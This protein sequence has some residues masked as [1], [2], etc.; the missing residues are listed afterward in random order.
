VLTDPQSVTLS[1]TAIS[2]PRLDERADTHVYTNR[3]SKVDLFV[4]QRVD[5]NSV[6]RSSV[7]LVTTVNV[8]DPVTGLVSKQRPS[9]NVSFAIPD[10]VL[11]ADL[12]ASYAALTNA[13]E[14]GTNALLKKILGGEK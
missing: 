8:T 6:A 4:T 12:E 9:V 14:A 10:G 1:G 5:K 13:L 2:L 7:S 3:A 11:S